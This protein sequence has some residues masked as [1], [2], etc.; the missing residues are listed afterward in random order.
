M[1]VR[2]IGVFWKGNTIDQHPAAKGGERAPQRGLRSEGLR[3]RRARA[4]RG[5]PLGAL[6]L[7]LALALT[8]TLG[9]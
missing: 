4:R 7:T 3:P 6:T 2:I 9:D 8:L 1:K 5:A